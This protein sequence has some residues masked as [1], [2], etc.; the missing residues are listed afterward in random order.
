MVPD[1]KFPRINKVIISGRLTRDVELRY[2]PKGTAVTRLSMAFDRSYKDPAGT[3][4]TISSFVDVVVWNKLAELCAEQVRKGSPVIVEGHL[5]MRSYV[6]NSNQNRHVMEVIAE[7][8]QFLEQKPRQ[9]Y[10]NQETGAAE[11]VSA[12]GSITDD[13]VPF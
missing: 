13:D 12:A 11:M 10:G 3:F 7:S 4:Q 2:T 8:V 6:D 1:L 5:E 9:D